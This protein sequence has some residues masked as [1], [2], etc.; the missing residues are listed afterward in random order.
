[1]RFNIL[2]F[3]MMSIHVNNAQTVQIDCD[4]N[5]CFGNYSGPEFIDGTDIAHQFSN[6]MSARVGDKLKEF[7]RNKAYKKVDFSNITMTTRGMGSGQVRF[8]LS[9]PFKRVASKCD[10]YTSFDHCGG[11]NHTPELEQRK[12]ELA[13]AL[14]NGKRLNISQL[15]KTSEGLQEYWIQW[16]N[17]S[18]Q[19]E[20]D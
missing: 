4:D 2:V 15:Q 17:K 5:K 8:S 18:V 9:I 14:L 7:Y 1:M 3:V 19:A 13:T 16:Q 10:A 11:W 12:K 6:K 20:C